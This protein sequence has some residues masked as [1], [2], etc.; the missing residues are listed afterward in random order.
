MAEHNQCPG[1]HGILPSLARPRCGTFILR[2]R[3]AATEAE[4]K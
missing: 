2:G 1:I 3:V 4:L